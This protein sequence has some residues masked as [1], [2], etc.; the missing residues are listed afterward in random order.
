MHASGRPTQLRKAVSTAG[1]KLT[2]AAA[3]CSPKDNATLLGGWMK[4]LGISDTWTQQEMSECI[5][6][7]RSAGMGNGYG[8]ASN[9][10]NM[11]QSEALIGE[12]VSRS[13]LTEGNIGWVGSS[14]H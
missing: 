14:K 10:S 5:D 1:G 6:D 12:L 3:S 9:K 13:N 7:P 11:T 4:L 2:P 8:R